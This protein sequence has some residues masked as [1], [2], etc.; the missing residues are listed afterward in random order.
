M[1]KYSLVCL[2]VALSLIGCSKQDDKAKPSAKNA[3]ASS[4]TAAAPPTSN[5]VAPSA[6][7]NAPVAVVPAAT[8]PALPQSAQPV[9]LSDLSSDQ[10]SGGI[11]EALGNGL[12]A[13][14][15]QLGKPGGFLS[16]PAVK[17][18]MPDKLQTVDKTLR[19]IGQGAMA[20]QFV[21]TMNQAAEQAVPAAASV[22]ADSL[23]TMTVAD[24]T[25]VLTGPD[26]AA[27]QYFRTATEADLTQ[28]FLPIVKEAT[29]KS[30]ATASYKQIMDKAKAAS[31]FFSAPSLD[32]DSYVTSKAMD[33]LFKMVAAQEKQIRQNPVARTTDLLKSVFGAVKK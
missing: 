26:D 2:A 6:P 8:T 5:A 30:G 29:A 32:L 21:A 7:A 17:I 28:K 27:T 16:N 18:P 4:A 12:Q 24:A 1:N 3:P 25:K 13:A 19:A 33:G 20:D 11:K 15:A 10:V 14:V 22:F 9:A 23:K 31:P